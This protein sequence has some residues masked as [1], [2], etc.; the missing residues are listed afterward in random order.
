MLRINEFN[1]GDCLTGVSDCGSAVM[2]AIIRRIYSGIIPVHV[3]SANKRSLTCLKAD[4]GKA[5]GGFDGNGR[6]IGCCCRAMTK[7]GGDAM[8][9]GYICV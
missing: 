3:A 1:M 8:P 2:I 5:V 9:V 6:V 4:I 7:G